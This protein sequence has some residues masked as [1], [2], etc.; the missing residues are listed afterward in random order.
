MLASYIWT[1]SYGTCSY[2][3]PFVFYAEDFEQPSVSESDDHAPE[4]EG[5]D[6]AS[7]NASGMEWLLIW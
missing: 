4:W 5:Q 6:G 3:G 1:A 2:G 7:I